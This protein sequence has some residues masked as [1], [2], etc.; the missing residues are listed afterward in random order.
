[1]AREKARIAAVTAELA[2]A[3]EEEPA[4]GKAATPAV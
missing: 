3:D 1:V 4:A 2:G